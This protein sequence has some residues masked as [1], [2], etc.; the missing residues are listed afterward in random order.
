MLKTSKIINQMRETLLER[1]SKQALCDLQNL[2]DFENL[3]KKYNFELIDTE[4]RNANVGFVASLLCAKIMK[5]AK[6]DTM[7]MVHQKEMIYRYK[8]EYVQLGSWV[9]SKPAEIKP[10]IYK[11]PLKNEFIGKRLSASVIVD[12]GELIATL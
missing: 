8:G 6:S 1:G 10:S 9:V 2:N 3:F 5:G 7:Q 12:N 11:L 4:A